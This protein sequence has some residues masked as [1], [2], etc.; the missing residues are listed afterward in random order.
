VRDFSEIKKLNKDK[1]MEIIEEGAD[2]GYFIFKLRRVLITVI[3]SF[4][5]GWDHVSVVV[6]EGRTPTWAEMCTIKN[7]FFYDDEVVMQ[8]HP[9]KS[10]YVNIHANCL[11]LWKPQNQAIPTP[12]KFM[13]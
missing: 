3:A 7:I 5:G 12:P 11:H 6:N 1:L 8:L 9:K 4:G 13:V 2:G 10:D